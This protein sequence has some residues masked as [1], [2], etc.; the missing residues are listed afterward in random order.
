MAAQLVPPGAVIADIGTDHAFLPVYLVQT[1]HCPRAIAA[2][3]G[4]GPLRNAA[5]TVERAGLRDSVELRLS[6]GFGSFSP[7]E[8]DCWIL[9]GMGG[10]LM[11]RLLERTA[12]L[13]HTTLVLQ[14][15]R[16]AWE[17]RAWLLS[18]GFMIE[19]ELA[20]FEAGRAY[21]ALRAIASKGNT[22]AGL[23]Y[24]YI[25]ELRRC[26]HPAAAEL[27][28]QERALLAARVRGLERIGRE[29]V[30]LDRLRAVLE[31]WEL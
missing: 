11:A 19:Q 7:G 28:R 29:G 24:L 6:D 9:T 10:T 22:P 21:G 16:H 13:C 17:A 12:W 20:C 4:E 23:S 25:G 30:E 2:D 18:H 3:I 14:P 26:P 8:A 15:M 1:G 27:L 31:E 5:K